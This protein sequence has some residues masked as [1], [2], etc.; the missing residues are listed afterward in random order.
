MSFLIKIIC[1]F[2]LTHI[3]IGMDQQPT[4]VPT[5][6]SSQ[7]IQ[8]QQQQQYAD[9][10]AQYVAGVVP[11]SPPS[12]YQYTEPN[13]G[14]QPE[15]YDNNYLIPY[16]PKATVPTHGDQ[17]DYDDSSLSSYQYL[18]S[19]LPYARVSAIILSKT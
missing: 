19:V 3:T 14:P 10:V 8:Q 12:A 15:A 11:Y 18:S 9:N 4:N 2:L 7:T 16:P 1:I 5:S 17:D 13:Y 6:P